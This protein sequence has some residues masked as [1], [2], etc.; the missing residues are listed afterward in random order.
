MFSC[1][2]MDINVHN[3]ITVKSFSKSTDYQRGT[4]LAFGRC[5]DVRDVSVRKGHAAIETDQKRFKP[6]GS[7]PSGEKEKAIHL[8]RRACQKPAS[9]L[10]RLALKG[11]PE[12]CRH[13]LKV[14]PPLI[15]VG[16]TPIQ[17]LYTRINTIFRTIS[18]SAGSNLRLLLHIAFIS[19]EA[20]HFAIAI[21]THGHYLNALPHSA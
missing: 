8:R 16:L 10:E 14:A 15:R 18:K 11:R 21:K 2:D 13:S 12:G 19:C 6:K 7:N 17:I 3:S 4:I 9:I 1:L 20:C 5:P